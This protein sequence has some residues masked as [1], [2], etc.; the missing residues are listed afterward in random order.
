MYAKEKE[1]NREVTFGNTK[2]MSRDN[3]SLSSTIS[4]SGEQGPYKP[5]ANRNRMVRLHHGGFT[6]KWSS[7]AY[8]SSFEN[9]QRLIAARG[10]KSYLRRHMAKAMFNILS[11]FSSSGRI[12]TG[13]GY[14]SQLAESGINTPR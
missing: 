4:S 10:F 2:I 5:L 8:D 12:S 11:P 1:S 7:L 13:Y 3:S 14:I 9:C 6:A